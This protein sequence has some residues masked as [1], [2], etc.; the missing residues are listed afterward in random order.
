VI[1]AP[2]PQKRELFCRNGLK[3]HQWLESKRIRSAWTELGRQR[4]EL[5]RAR[6]TDAQGRLLTR[7]LDLAARMAG[8]SCR[9]MLWQ[10]A[11]QH[12]KTSAE[13]RLQRS[14]RRALKALKRDFEAYWPTRNKGTTE[15]CSA[16]LD[17]RIEDYRKHKAAFCEQRA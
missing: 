16:F 3:Y 2:P 4:A 10:Q 1:A 17:W 9:F 11:I 8:E 15:K 12:G 7:E 5:K 6:P 14:G 13:R